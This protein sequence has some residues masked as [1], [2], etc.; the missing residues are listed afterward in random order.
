MITAEQ[1]RRI[2]PRV[3][4]GRWLDPLINTLFEF[5]IDTDRRLAA[6]IAQIAHESGEFRYVRELATGQAYEGRRDLGNTEAGDGQRFKGRGLIQITGRRNY[7]ACGKAL[8]LDLI[9][10]PERLEE[11]EFAARSAGWYWQ[12]HGC[13]ELADSENFEAITRRINGGLNGYTERLNY[14]ARAKDVLT[15][16]TMP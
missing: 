13:N 11:P 7:Y 14:W 4:A 10:H 6:F 1:L 2:M 12:T 16:D 15:E 9:A 5:E 3:D 8:G